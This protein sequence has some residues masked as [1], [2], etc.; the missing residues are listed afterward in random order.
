[1]KI[2]FL[3]DIVG[4]PGRRAVRE[5]LP[6]IVSE[7]AIDFVIANCENAAAGFG[8]TREIVEELYE[9]HIDVLTSGNHIWDKK[10]VMDFIH[11]YET[12][13]RPAN[14]PE[15]TPGFGSVVVPCISGAYVAVINLIGRIFMQPLDC[16]FKVAQGEIEKLKRKTDIIFVDIHAEATSEKIA[17]G[18]FLD[19]QVSAVVGTHTHV[20]TADERVLPGGTAYITDVGMTGPFD[21]VIGIKKD[22][23]LDRFLTGIPNKFDV[24]KNDVWLQGVIVHL[25]DKSGKSSGIQRISVTLRD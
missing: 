22:A 15:G 17:M 5:Q 18:W 8:V 23:V 16:P 20:Q 14:Y 4:K 13:L 1:M 2:L 6:K 7:Y 12:L 21:S 19:G 11:D 9:N 3:G 24:A 25:D 10:E